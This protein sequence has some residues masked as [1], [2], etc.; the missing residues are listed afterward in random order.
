M[1]TKEKQRKYMVKYRKDHPQYEHPPKKCI[2]C[3]EIFQTF[4]KRKCDKC[5]PVI[6]A[7]K[8]RFEVFKRDN[9][10]CQYCGRKAPNVILHLDHIFPKSK[11]GKNEK[12]NYITSCE[13]CNL[14]KGNNI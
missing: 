11:G 3:G 5:R 14:G 7:L 1:W 4:K 10:T 8:V 9:F 2:E 12:E 13:E 6:R